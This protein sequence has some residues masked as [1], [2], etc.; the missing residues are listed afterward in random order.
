MSLSPTAS[1]AQMSTCSE[2]QASSSTHC[3]EASTD[4]GRDHAER[5]VRIPTTV[6]TTSSLD[7]DSMEGFMVVHQKKKQRQR[8]LMS[9]STHFVVANTMK[10]A[11]EIYNN[12]SRTELVYLLSL[13]DAVLS[14]ESDNANIVMEKCFCV[15]VRT[16]KK[17]NTVRLQPQGFIFFEEN[18]ARMLLWVKCIHG[19][20]K[21]A[22][23][24]DSELFR[25][26]STA[27]S[28]IEPVWSFSD[29][30]E[31]RSKLGYTIAAVAVSGDD[32]LCASN[33]TSP[34]T[35]PT[36]SSAFASAREKLTQR[37]AIG[38]AN[39]IATVGRTMLTPTR[40][41][42][43][44]GE[45]Q[46]NR[47]GS[48]LF[49]HDKQ[50]QTRSPMS[51]S[52][53][54]PPAPPIE[55]SASPR[56]SFKG[57][58]STKVATDVSSE[59]AP[60][61]N[62]EPVS[63]FRSR[64]LRAKNSTATPSKNDTATVVP[65]A[66]STGNL[67]EVA[68]L[69]AATTTPDISEPLP[70]ET[71]QQ[72][73]SAELVDD[74]EPVA[75][76]VLTIMLAVAII[77]GVSGASAFLPLALAG[78]LAHFYNQHQYFTTWTLSSVAVYLTSSYH[79]LFG[80]GTASILLYLWGYA[81]FKTSR[82]HRL[83]RKAVF[84]FRGTETKQD[85]AHVE[86]PNWMRYPD[87][88]RVE[89]LNKVFVSGWP[90]LKKAIENSVLGS[91]NPALDAQK[92]AFMSSLSLIRLN[93][94]NQTPHIAS[95]KYISAD[96]LTDEVTLDVEVRILTDKKTFAA[97]LKIVS[98][99]GAAVCLSLRELLL[100]GTLRITLNPMAEFWPCFGG[101]SL[102]FTERPLFDFSLTA[103][104]INIANVP[105]V[106]EWLHTFL[107]DL[108]IDYF[109]W[110]NVLSIPLWDEHGNRIQ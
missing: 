8:F 104:K 79:V 72:N 69:Q 24:L 88:D 25:S 91:V 48:M 33:V 50:Q 86:I 20:I 107:N 109:V 7:Q 43:V 55:T 3:D 42:S 64:S 83:Q 70:A 27:S 82:R 22:T 36:G 62:V 51:S 94:G 46:P 66:K 56:L 18:Q 54:D 16:W 100:V 89:W 58:R 45:R 40:S 96:T 60:S 57:K 90:Y 98:H 11:L 74:P 4:V 84:H 34:G 105:F 49:S 87:V 5:S 12:E 1:T 76:R 21:Q 73:T 71:N 108:L 101:L 110:P 32:S 97:D 37:L 102:C 80:I 92:P 75:L 6:R 19:A 61:Q 93:L 2:S 28:S 59:T 15:E 99:L 14:F 41:A 35:S 52:A 106:S 53:T 65:T 67:A 31:S 81:R 38:S 68:P 95:V 9:K 10:Q 23:T 17:K 44:S 13:A 47:W 26:P 85:I 30:D 78:S 29:S 39:R 103:A 77:A 63:S